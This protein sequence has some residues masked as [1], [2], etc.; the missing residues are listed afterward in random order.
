M[1]LHR[2]ALP[3]VLLAL[4]A[5]QAH[6]QDNQ[7][8]YLG[9]DWRG[10]HY[11]PLETINRDT[12]SRLG[13]AWQ[14]ATGTR[15]GMEA[16]PVVVD[17]VL[18]ASGVA[19]RVYALD[20]A[21]GVEQWRFEPAVDMQVVRGTCCDQ[22][23][24]GVSVWQGR[25]YVASLDGWLYALDA[26]NGRVLWKVDTIID[27]KRA[28][29]STGAPL[30]AGD[31]VV[32][33]NAG[34]E[35]DVRGYVTAYALR[36][37]RQRWRFYTV[38]GDP[39]RG[40]ENPELAAAA[41]TWDPHSAWQYGGGGPVWD[42]MAYDP[43]LDLLYVGTGNAGTYPQRV[44][45]P[46]GGDNLYTCS[47]LALSPK[48]G[49]LAWHYQETPG[50]QWDFDADAPMILVDRRINGV[51]RQLLLHA[52][53]SGVFYVLDRS[54]GKLVS[55]GK[56]ATANWTQ[57]VDPA[58]GRPIVDHEAADYRERA[59]LVFPSVI[60]AHSWQP[61]AYSPLT[62]LVYLPT[63]EAGNVLYD[64]SAETGYRPSLFNANVGLMLNGFVDDLKD[65]LPPAVRRE[66]DSGRLMAGHPDRRMYA[67]LQAW[68]PL[69]QK[70]VWRSEASD[71]W[72]HA[73]V[74]ASAGGLVVQ[75][76]DRGL[77]RVFDADSGRL[78][79]SIDT[80][81]SIIAAPAMYQVKGA[82]YIA[83]LTGT[84]GG[85]WAVAHP[86]SAAYRRGNVG[87]ILAF[88]LDGGAVPLPPL[89][90]AD[91]PFPRPPAQQAS[92]ATIARGAKLF[93]ENCAICHPN[94]TR[95][96]SSDLRR[97]S[98]GV[99]AS[100]ND[101]VLQGLMRET[102]MPSWGDVLSVADAGAIHAFLIDLSQR[103]YA[104][105]MP[106][107]SNASSRPIEPAPVAHGQ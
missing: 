12:V 7:W 87:R 84:G 76:N 4:C 41:S 71:W 39:A 37:G 100:F 107:A 31:V 38:P 20:A 80:G 35:F 13:F 29:S 53:K 95:S 75:G 32:I 74:L 40:F 47:I 42:G 44:R 34:G 18:Y 50:D 102:G 46:A 56:F 82:T 60:G 57:G 11:S 62:G 90:P 2:V 3:V 96:A 66:Y 72:D 17:G 55:A 36:D 27:R 89:L 98:A 61:M 78:L 85:G 9:G 88:R 86:E 103:A 91:A 48:T 1:K 25:V 15:R 26:A 6:H 68:D 14:F 81:S 77:L 63:L 83:V 79:K 33:G 51:E 73:G 5:C 105:A 64:S 49:R 59:K 93:G 52:P 92:A 99:H 54:N 67:Y 16:T 94:M 69:A 28:Y 22:V 24:R 104:A 8:S 23:N 43:Q 21:S 101:I 106:P 97:M 30:I 58:T 65:S 19:G 45:S 70:A 10:T